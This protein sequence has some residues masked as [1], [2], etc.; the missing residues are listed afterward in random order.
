MLRATVRIKVQLLFLF[1]FAALA[2]AAPAGA[3]EYTVVTCNGQAAANGGWTLYASGPNSALSENCAASGGSMAAVLA[4]NQAPAASVAMWQVYAPANTTVAGATLTRKVAVA[5]T[6]Y[7]YV[8][9]GVTPAAANYQVFENCSGPGGCKQEIA[10]GSFAWRSARADVNRIQVYVQC[11]EPCQKLAG[12]EAAALRLSRADIALTDNAVPTIAAGPSSTMFASA[13]PVS[14]VQSITATFKDA[15][16]GVAA[17]GVQVDGQTVNET[18]V[19]NAGCRTPYRRLVPCPLTVATTLQFKPASVPDGPHQLRVFAR[20][21]TGSN[22]GYS[23]SFPVTTSARGAI[24]G[25]NGSDQARLTVGVR[26]AVSAGH[27]GPTPHATLDVPYNARTVAEG[28][29]LNSAG[30]AITGARLTV[31]TAVDR[32]VPTYA[33][34]PTDVITD[35]NG[36]FRVTLPRGPSWRVRVLYFARALDDAPAGRDDARVRVATH[37]TFSPRR[38]HLRA[39]Q[40]AVFIGHVVGSYRPAAIRV[41]LQGRRRGRYVTL[42]TAATQNR[43]TYRLSYRFTGDARGR[44]VFRLRVRHFPRFPYFLGYSRPVNVFVR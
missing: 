2:F 38:R 36:R 40:R 28:R 26:R 14:G 16:G 41:E 10:R 6:G 19:A 21:A 30:Q 7:H 20:D 12:G 22:V 25:A 23:E 33:D 31:A 15:G 8:A 4:G 9:R 32:G 24:N 39:G 5:G 42:A 43:G 18:P 37:A 17:T 44:Y 27:H 35:A 13:D 34:L 11:V 3:A 1:V 29:L